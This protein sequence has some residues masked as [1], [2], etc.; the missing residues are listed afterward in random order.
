MVFELGMYVGAALANSLLLGI[1]PFNFILGLVLCILA[2]C[3]FSRPLE[4]TSDGA[5]Y[6]CTI[7]GEF[8]HRMPSTCLLSAALAIVWIGGLKND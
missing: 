7:F 4:V 6:F 2:R 1:A 8:K 3:F 5:M